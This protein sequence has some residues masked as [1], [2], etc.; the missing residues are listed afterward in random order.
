[1]RP[2]ISLFDFKNAIHDR[3]SEA[4][5]GYRVRVVW[6]EQDAPQPE[7]PFVALKIISGPVLLSQFWGTVQNDDLTRAGKEVEL[8]NYS[9]GHFTISCEA[10]VSRK[11]SVAT[12]FDALAVL[13]VCRA[14]MSRESTILFFDTRGIGFVRAEPPNDLSALEETSF[15]SRANLDLVFSVT[16]EDSDFVTYIQKVELESDEL[17]VDMVVGD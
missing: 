5:R 9:P 7:L 1:M 4:L 16:L 12:D 8:A 17:G 13:S 11:S 6:R 10:F 14:A 3:I 2:P 15:T